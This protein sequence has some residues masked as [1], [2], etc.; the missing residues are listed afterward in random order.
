MTAENIF[1][2]QRNGEGVR[3]TSNQHNEA[4]II[5]QGEDNRDVGMSIQ[6]YGNLILTETLRRL[7]IL[8]VRE[9]D[10]VQR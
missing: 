3:E 5:K 4:Q 10:E 7:A 9:K 2:E 6:K 1:Q 8:M